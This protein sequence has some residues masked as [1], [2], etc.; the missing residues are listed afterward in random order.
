MYIS[1]IIKFGIGYMLNM[2]EWLLEN[3]F[4]SIPRA[5][6][7]RCFRLKTLAVSWV[8]A[9][10]T[11][12]TGVCQLRCRNCPLI[13]YDVTGLDSFSP[14]PL[15]S[16]HLHIVITVIPQRFIAG[17]SPAPSSDPSPL[18]SHTHT[19]TLTHTHTHTH[20][21]T[22]TLTHTHTHTHTHTILRK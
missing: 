10:A 6:W 12:R 13:S 21:H 5:A 19:H 11:W 9:R 16:S 1:I 14:F 22:H 20:S 7:K 17:S 18:Q 4:N 2:F 3:G 15:S 8:E